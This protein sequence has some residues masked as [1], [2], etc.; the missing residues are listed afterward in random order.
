M[1]L[2]VSGPL[3]TVGNSGLRTLVWVS[4]WD[5]FS[6]DWFMPHGHCYLWIPELVW[7]HVVS[8]SLTGLAYIVISLTLY[9]L[10]RRVRL[11]FT[12]MF[13]AFGVF[14][15]ACGLTHFV[16]VWNVWR[17]AYW[18][19]GLVKAVTAIASV[20]T[21]VLLIPV[22]PKVA[23]VARAAALSEKRRVQLEG[24]HRELQRLYERVRE[25]D[26]AKTRFFAN[27][28]HELRTPLTLIQGPVDKLLRQEGI[29]DEQRAD[30]DVVRRNARLLH[31][32]VND[33]LDVAKLEAGEMDVCYAQVDLADLIRVAAAHFDGLAAERSI[34]YRVDAPESLPAQVDADKT[35]RVL[36]NLLSNA[37]KHT[38]DRGTVRCALSL[39]A[40]ARHA[41]LAVADSGPGIELAQRG[42]VFERFR[43]IE[44]DGRELGGT[45]LGL[46]I[47][48]DF[49]ELQRGQIGIADAPEGGALFT[50][51]LPLEA[52]Y[53][54]KLASGGTGAAADVASA[55]VTAATAGPP[56]SAQVSGE[57]LAMEPLVGEPAVSVAAAPLAGEPAASTRATVL[58]VEDNVDMA[59]HLADTLSVE[60]RVL[61]AA[62]GREGLD[63][64]ES[65]RPD[66]VVTDISMP[67]LSGDRLVTAVRARRELDGIPIVVLTARADDE[68]RMRVLRAGAQD[69]LSKPFSAEE[70]RAR[71][72]NQMTLKR[73]RDVLL[74]ELAMQRGDL[75]A[76]AREV[77]L[78]KRELEVALESMRVAREQAEEASQ[79]KSM[80]LSLV[81]HELR[82]PLF[83]LQLNL[84]MLRR[85]GDD[86]S[87]KQRE[88]LQRSTRASDRLL[89]LIDSILEYTR[90][91]SGHVQVRL[92]RVDLGELAREVH[93]ELMLQAEHKQLELV[94]DVAPDV[95]PALT[96]A[97]LVRLVLVNLVVNAIKYTDAGQVGVRIRHDA[98]GHHLVVRDTGAGIPEDQRQHIFDPFV[99][100]QPTRAH[101][102]GVGLG[103]ALVNQMVR[104][105]G[106][107]ISFTSEVGKG[108]TFTVILSSR[109]D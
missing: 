99:Q 40:D 81:S 97:R 42:A 72:H 89:S 22:I 45:G 55:T 23:A 65:L 47:C 13:W 49:V 80:F 59:R 10:V 56:P 44:G 4:M 27:V 62:D 19:A 107:R 69:Y 43:Q 21:S 20:A 77:T 3:C 9:A 85:Q 94:I 38:P 103:L 30:L 7:L 60:Y 78:R 17:A 53:M 2:C 29:S 50:V 31:K 25:L 98:E 109:P 18:E 26:E 101:T 76:L 86:L 14:I 95:P 83:A 84:E 28:S 75:E 51:E 58:V 64:I 104:S 54:V 82:T 48:K 52:P 24:S 33:L 1:S 71:V 34:Q 90:L 8:D 102:S 15:A 106:G 108:S 36:L 73:A 63:Q 41:V 87:P 93:D 92:G 100:L 16:E 46:A 12:P 91:Q 37:F 105:L 67:F 11:P 66:L 70:L 5:F 61:C 74:G 88:Q 35:Q 32:H 96:D 39:G 6:S 79:A 68:M 57:P